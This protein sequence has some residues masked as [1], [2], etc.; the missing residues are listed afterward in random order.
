MVFG[1]PGGEGRLGQDAQGGVHAVV[2]EA[3]ELGAEDGVGTGVG[4]GEVDVLRRAGKGVLLEAHLGDG[5]AV[6]DVL[7]AEAKIDL[8]AGGENELAGGEVVASVLVGGVKADGVAG[9]GVDEGGVGAAEGGVGA[10]GSGSTR[11]TACR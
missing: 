10:G 8:A 7:G 5:E 6:D 11:R 3:A 9:T 2:A 4:R 1:E